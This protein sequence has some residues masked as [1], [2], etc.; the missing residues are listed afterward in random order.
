VG[1]HQASQRTASKTTKEIEIKASAISGP[2]AP[3]LPLSIIRRCTSRI[4]NRERRASNPYDG[5]TLETVIPEIDAQI[6]VN[7]IRIVADRSRRGHNAP[8]DHR[9]KVYI[10]GQRRSDT[11]HIKRE[12][13]RRSAVEP[14]IGHGK[15]QT[16]DGPQ[17]PRRPHGDAINA[18]LAA[19]GLNFRRL[20]A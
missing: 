8:P 11:E 19:A 4:G 6:G 15:R 7:L 5:H 3:D 18:V 13:R 9:F 10:L 2:H 1:S 14:V 12:L 17:S 20:L 16:S